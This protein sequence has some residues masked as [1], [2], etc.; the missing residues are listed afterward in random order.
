MMVVPS[1]TVIVLIRFSPK[2]SFCEAEI[3]AIFVA[4]A[5]DLNPMVA[6]N[7]TLPTK[8]SRQFGLTVNAESGS[9]VYCIFLSAS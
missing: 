7:A 3:S 9:I 5:V 6:S 2:S 8:T 1:F 4:I